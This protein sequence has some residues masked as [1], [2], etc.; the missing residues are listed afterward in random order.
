MSRSRRRC[1]APGHNDTSVLPRQPFELFCHHTS[2]TPRNVGFKLFPALFV[3]GSL[4]TGT[5]SLWSHLVDLSDGHVVSG[6]LT[7]KG[8]VSRKEKDFF[9]DP[10]MWQR[11]RR[12]YERIWP[13][14]PPH[15][16]ERVSVDATPAYH[17]WYDAPKNMV[18]FFG[19]APATHLRLVWM[20]RDPVSKFWSY[21]W[22]L[23]AY[24]GDW[25][26]VTFDAFI[27][28][29]LART[30]ECQKL[31]PNTPLW[32]PSMPP[33]FRNCAP[34]LDHG[35]Y[36]P[37][38]RRWLTYFRP[39]QFLLISFAGYTRRP[40]AVVKDV[41]LHAGLPP[42]AAIK[43][44]ARVRST[45]LR[46]S[47]KNSKASGHGRLSLNYRDA[48]DTLY[49]PFVDRLYALIEEHAMSVSPCEHQGTRFL[50]PAPIATAN[51][52]SS[53]HAP[54]LRFGS[55]GGGRHLRKMGF[56]PR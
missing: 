10:T 51:A 12:W 48:L 18:T 29:K 23:K 43:A 54:L 15:P 25:D 20:L 13:K 33:P 56:A 49:R 38:M 24:G 44:A 47:N 4:K 16:E 55:G 2:G 30:R 5:T 14:C 32:P 42:P 6:A 52:S 39:S 53:A 17:V 22:E 11:G 50:D 46:T 41:M 1:P 27:A 7:D 19:Q 31:D 35:L 9:G 37:Q 3:I 28:P 36:E 21:F 45:V 34:H 26:R 8:D 40:A